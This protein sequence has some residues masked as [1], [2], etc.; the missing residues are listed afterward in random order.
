[1]NI[2]PLKALLDIPG[3]IGTHIAA[4]AI[5]YES[6]LART[7][8]VPMFT[9]VYYSTIDDY[10]YLSRKS[11]ILRTDIGRYCSIASGCYI[12]M[13][14]HRTDWISTSPVFFEGKNVFNISLS[15]VRNST[16]KR[17]RIGNDVWIGTNVLINEGIT[18][19]DGAVIGAGAVVT[20]DIEPYTIVGG[21]PAREIRKRFSTEQIEKLLRI[22][23][24]NK[25]INELKN[26]L[27]NIDSIEEYLEKEI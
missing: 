10:S 7:V 3:R 27:I 26:E 17:T 12:G 5:V 22:K 8:V 24:W 19:G 13:P 9:K 11:F 25:S 20:K 16:I 14:G 6:K 23:W 15:S 2:S 21:I 4:L 1:M 18:V